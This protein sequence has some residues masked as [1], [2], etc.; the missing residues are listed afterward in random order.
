M[1]MISL[2]MVETSALI[3]KY[4][5][6]AVSYTPR[7]FSALI[8]LVLGYF[9]ARWVKNI[10][11][12]LAS[13]SR[14]DETLSLFLASIIEWAVL[15]LVLIAVLQR[16]GIQTTSLAAV[17]GATVLA[18][19]MAL[20]GTLGNVA[21]GVML[22]VFRPYKLGDV[23]EVAGR[24]GTV[25]DIT[26]FT[27]ELSTLD[28]VKVIIANGQAWGSTIANYSAYPTRRVDLVFGIDY[29]D[30]IEK[31]EAIILK[32]IEN[33][34][35]ILSQPEPWVRVTSLGE[36]SVDLTLRVWAKSEDYWEVKFK[37]IKAIK[38]AFDREGITIPYPHQVEIQ[39]TA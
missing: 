21:A 29:G 8:I 18:V 17:L 3:E 33:D 38:E 28:N 25:K 22:I 11:R 20:Q 39:K 32:A 6:L 19:G 16:F 35:R 30:D 5:D 4:V 27:T 2:T 12:K 26:I 23:V 36:S 15:A 9:I 31:A 37:A 14:L 13:K 24:T 1:M 34:K 7:V 10:V